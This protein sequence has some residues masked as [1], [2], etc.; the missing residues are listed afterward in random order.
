MK[1]LKKQLQ[2]IK[3][4]KYS[5]E[6]ILKLYRYLRNEVYTKEKLNDIIYDIEDTIISLG[7][8]S[9][10]NRNPLSYHLGA[11]HKSLSG[12]SGF[13]GLDPNKPENLAELNNWNHAYY[14]TWNNYLNYYSSFREIVHGYPYY[15]FRIYTNINSGVDN[16]EKGDVEKSLRAD[17]YNDTKST[18]QKMLSNQ[19]LRSLKFGT[20]NEYKVMVK[21]IGNY[22]RGNDE[23]GFEIRVYDLSFVPKD[24]FKKD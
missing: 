12:S 4:S 5:E 19:L 8:L 9:L 3:E 13:P 10:V 18:L 11:A 22:L 7:F 1:Y 21:S 17:W 24:P 23:F 20:T 16:I 14:S 15:E 6:D 2:Y